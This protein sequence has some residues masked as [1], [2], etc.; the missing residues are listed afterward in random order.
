MTTND[1]VKK[2]EEFLRRHDMFYGQMPLKELT[3]LFLEEMDA[4]LRGEPSSL[5]MIPSFVR[6]DE[7]PLR[8]EPVLVIDAGGTNLRAGRAHISREGRVVLEACGKQKM[9]GTGGSEI[10]AE[11]MMREIAAFAAEFAWGCRYACISFS[12]ACEALPDG[13]G[14]ILALCKELQVRGAEGLLVCSELE[15]AMRRTGV[16]GERKWKMINDSVGSL[17]GGMAASDR[18]GYDDYIGYILGTGMNVCCIL[19]SSSVVKSPEAAAMG[20]DTVVN[21]EAGCFSRALRGT[22]DRMLDEASEIPGDHLTEKMCSGSYYKKLLKQTLALAAE[23]GVLSF[24]LEDAPL[25]LH[26]TNEKLDAFCVSP[27]AGDPLS[28][29][30]AT[31]EDRETAFMINWMLLER[32]ARLSAACF[33]AVMEKRG[34]RPDGRVCICSD[35]SMIRYNPVVRP[36]IEAVLREARPETTIDFRFVEDASLLGCAWAG[37]P[38]GKRA[39]RSRRSL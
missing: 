20:G 23:D 1:P 28:A 34:I 10:E 15:Q 7:E 4:G 22:A 29:S 5:F 21:L 31:D 19:P 17:L 16:P 30:L 35:G 32:C 8:G 36:R 27:R 11:R 3:G 6:T 9:P 25:G 26:I 13:D 14:R 33:L 37:L 2:A 12:Y 18:S 24:R 39:K 38:G